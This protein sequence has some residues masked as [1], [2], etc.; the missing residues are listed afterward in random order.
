MEGG[1]GGHVSWRI[2]WRFTLILEACSSTSFPFLKSGTLCSFFYINHLDATN[3]SITY[4]LCSKSVNRLS[5]NVKSHVCFYLPSRVVDQSRT[6]QL[7]KCL[8]MN[9]SGNE[10][11]K[12]TCNSGQFCLYGWY[13]CWSDDNLGAS[14]ALEHCAKALR[15]RRG[16]EWGTEVT[17]TDG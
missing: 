9:L 7:M 2:L 8:K 13:R 17:Q 3:V 12:R 6:N 14:V 11:W 15:S 16:G 5:I 10:R 1:G 4:R